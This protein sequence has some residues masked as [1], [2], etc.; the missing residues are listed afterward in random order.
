MTDIS[1]YPAPAAPGSNAF[2][3]FEFGVSQFG[4]IPTF[5]W[6]S[7]IISQYAN[8]QTL[9]TLVANLADDID[10]TE[11]YDNFYDLIWNV[12]TAQGYGLD[13]WG[14]IV[15]VN[16]NLR[17]Q[18]VNYFGFKQGVTLDNFAPGGRSPFY[19][20]A[21]ITS[22]Y[23]L[24]DQAYRQLILAKAAVNISD[25]SIPKLNAI[26]LSLFG[27]RNPFAP[28]GICYV[29]NGFNMSMTYTFEFALTALQQAIIYQSGVLPTPGGVV[30]TVVAP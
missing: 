25:G 11:N 26:L 4:D 2:G 9:L 21:P 28:G 10:Q 14:V 22:N 29:T 17:V 12:L 23:A 3:E 27:P 15:G 7:T 24:T 13:I 6:R 18:N 5:D 8:S 30:A 19:I 1:F 20:G 16:R